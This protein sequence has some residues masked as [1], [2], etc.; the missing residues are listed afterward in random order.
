MVEDF[1]QYLSVKD[2]AEHKK[3]LSSE[4]A[5][6]G[7]EKTDETGRLCRMNLAVHGIEGDIKHGGNVNSCYDDPHGVTGRFD[8]AL[9]NPPFNVNA[10]YGAWKYKRIIL[11]PDNKDF[12]DIILENVFGEDF[13][14]VAEFLSALS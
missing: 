6:H 8:F 12:K 3:N 1:K 14:V 11:S 4:L 2:I 10:V 13:R 7:V 5:I 9:A